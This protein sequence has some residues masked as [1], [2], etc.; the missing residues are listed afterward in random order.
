MTMVALGSI[1]ARAGETGIRG[2]KLDVGGVYPRTGGGNG[3]V[4]IAAF[5]IGGLS[6]H[7][8]G[9]PM[10]MSIHQWASGSI[11]ARAGETR[12]SSGAKMD[13]RVYP[14]TGGETLARHF[15]RPPVRVYPRTGGGNY[16]HR[17]GLGYQQG[18]SPHGRGKRKPSALR[19]HYLRSIPARA[20]ETWARDG[21]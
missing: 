8:R 14:R 17:A 11:P 2:G 20:G 4:I 5:W 13:G 7:G 21:Y 3:A 1:P 6:P 10:G 18:L 16:C 15:P 19:H 9:K 12:S